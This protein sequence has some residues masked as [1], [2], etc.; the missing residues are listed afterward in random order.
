MGRRA[1]PAAG[2][3]LAAGVLAALAAARRLLLHVTVDGGSMEPLLGH[4]DRVLALRTPPAAVTRGA[5]VV[6]RPP[7]VGR[8][9]VR[10][11]DPVTGQV[12]LAQPG[13]PPYFVKRVVGLPGDRVVPRHAVGPAAATDPV[14]VPAGAYFVEGETDFSV[15]SGLWGPVP[16][17]RLLGVVVLRFRTG[18]TRRRGEPRAP[19]QP[20]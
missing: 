8:A 7:P 17:D 13:D 4:G 3:A 20:A 2:L 18:R 5:V 15:D 6:G 12:L 16:A 19:A 9:P 10:L 11:R 14:T 1:A